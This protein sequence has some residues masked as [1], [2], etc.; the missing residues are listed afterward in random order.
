[1]NFSIKI[2][3]KQGSFQQF[4]RSRTQNYNNENQGACR[5][6]QPI[7]RKKLFQAQ[8]P[9]VIKPKHF[10]ISNGSVQGTPLIK[11]AIFF[12]N[13]QYVWISI[14]TRRNTSKLGKVICKILLD[15]VTFDIPRKA[16][17]KC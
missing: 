5:L 14:A 12:G 2:E 9:Q 8:T 10:N 1:M 16:K 6:L 3:K 11:M 7:Q 4:H 17:N 15:G 13:K